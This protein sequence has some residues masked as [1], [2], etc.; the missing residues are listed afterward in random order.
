MPRPG[1][2]ARTGRIPAALG[3]V[4]LVGVVALLGFGRVVIGTPDLT[5][6]EPATVSA[7]VRVA[8]A[9]TGD[10]ALPAGSVIRSVDGLERPGSIRFDG[11]D[12]AAFAAALGAIAL[13][14]CTRRRR[15]RAGLAAAGGSPGARSTRAPPLRVA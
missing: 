7:V 9:F 2:T 10:P 6:P 5:A 12:G 15:T 14:A 13:A 4:A 1:R 8:A 11:G 3:V